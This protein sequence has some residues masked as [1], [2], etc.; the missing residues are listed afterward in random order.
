MKEP[1]L[2]ALGAGLQ[3]VEEPDAVADLVERVGCGVARRPFPQVLLI[4]LELVHQFQ[5]RVA[6]SSLRGVGGVV[7]ENRMHER[8]ERAV[9]NQI[10]MDAALRAARVTDPVMVDKLCRECMSAPTAQ[11]RGILKGKT[12]TLTG[13]IPW[14]MAWSASMQNRNLTALSASSCSLGS[15]RARAWFRPGR[16]SHSPRAHCTAPVMIS[17]CLDRSHRLEVIACFVLGLFLSGEKH[18]GS[19]PKGEAPGYRVSEGNPDQRCR[20]AHYLEFQQAI[21]QA[22]Y[23]PAGLEGGVQSSASFFHSLGP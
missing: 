7:A 6:K 21:G 9:S 10:V 20:P 14:Y 18:L 4:D 3:R 16:K 17:P 5:R 22:L 1:P 2:L 13:G 12:W 8:E 15:M 23:G 19:I 11:C